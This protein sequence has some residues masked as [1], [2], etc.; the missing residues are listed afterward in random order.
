MLFK[1]LIRNTVMAASVILSMLFSAP[2]ASAQGGDAAILAPLLEAWKGSQMGEFAN[3]LRMALDQ[4]STQ[5]EQL[6]NAKNMAKT[7]KS[8]YEALTALREG[9]ATLEMLY[10]DANALHQR[11]VYAYNWTQKAVTDGDITIEEAADFTLLLEYIY[12]NA[13]SNVNNMFRLFTTD[14]SKLPLTEKLRQ[15]Y[16][17]AEDTKAD[18][19]ALDKTIK[20]K[21]DDIVA[22]N[23][24]NAMWQ[25]VY[26]MYGNDSDF[27]R[28]QNSIIEE[29][30]K[31]RTVKDAATDL[32]QADKEQAESGQTSGGPVSDDGKAIKETASVLRDSKTGSSIL[33]I[34]C[35][36]I[37]ILAL[38]MSIPALIKV[39]HGERQSQ[40]ALYKLIM[41]TVAIIFIIQVFGRLILK[42]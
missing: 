40:D 3:Q 24:G 25:I 4:W 23:G 32:L 26:G 34:V 15:L 36:I 6:E 27:N 41:G 10:D 11:C 39:T 7:L 13:I 38:I 16:K 35:F 22:T 29:M 33:N 30:N 5:L 20:E 28:A 17:A 8:G 42:L 12:R 14:S 37:G 2:S 9:A 21:E 18:I 19:T 31:R 1:K